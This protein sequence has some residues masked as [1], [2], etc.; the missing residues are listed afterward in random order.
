MK[1]FGL[2]ATNS[3]LKKT[4]KLAKKSEMEYVGTTKLTSLARLMCGI[5]PTAPEMY[6]VTVSGTKEQFDELVLSFKKERRKL[7]RIF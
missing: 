3:E 6:C 1:N 2:F 5:S 4:E 7:T